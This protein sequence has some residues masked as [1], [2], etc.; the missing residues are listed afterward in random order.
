[1]IVPNHT[2][3][4]RTDPLLP[5]RLSVF[6]GQSGAG[7]STLLNQ[8]SPELNLATGDLMHWKRT[9]YNTSCGTDS[10]Y[11]GLVANTPGFELD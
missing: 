7:K 5:E 1:M 4:N 3:D 6:M 9:A 11:G 2:G 10:I 8:I